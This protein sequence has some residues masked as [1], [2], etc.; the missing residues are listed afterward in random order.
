LADALGGELQDL[1]SGGVKPGVPLNTA[2]KLVKG[3]F[4]TDMTFAQ[5]M[6]T[7]E[8]PTM[9]GISDSF[10]CHAAN[11]PETVG[12]PVSSRGF[13]IPEERGENLSR[14]DPK[15]DGMAALRIHLVYF[16]DKTIR[17]R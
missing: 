13:Q 4:D 11:R 5:A 16:L 17:Y 6:N 14:F 2:I 1:S 10:L 9:L 15:T 8:I 3:T 7:A 12:R